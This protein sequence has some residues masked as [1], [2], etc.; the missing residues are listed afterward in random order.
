MM[1]PTAAAFSVSTQFENVGDAWIHRELIR[2]VAMRA[3]TWV[4]V[5][6]CPSGFVANLG[7]DAL[8]G[9]VRVDGL[10]RLLSRVLRHRRE[11]GQTAWF[12]GPGGYHGERSGPD[13][14]RAWVATGVLA[15]LHA[16]GARICLVG[17]SYERLGRRHR[18]VLATRGRLLHAHLVRDEA[19]AAYARSLG[20]NVHGIA[21][22]LAFADP[23]W[24]SQSP[25]D[26]VTV[27]LVFRSD[28][29]ATQQA[30]VVDF[31]RRLA[32]AAHWVPR[33]RAIAQVGRDQATAVAVADAVREAG[34]QADVVFVDHALTAARAAYVGCSHVLGNRLHGLLLGASTGAIPVPVVD[35]E[36]QAKIGGAFAVLPDGPQVIASASPDAV[37]RAA[38]VLADDH[39]RPLD[40]SPA[41]AVLEAAFDRILGPPSRGADD[42]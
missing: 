6:R 16:A 13:L 15:A 32:R 38:A 8:P 37:E 17:V 39:K 22:D 35:P 21:A 1:R 4:D 33:W 20:I 3:P 42:A 36:R 27:A 11:G 18:D 9:V 5:T 2:L 30:E 12:L 19:S 40:P 26:A 29:H 23:A 31:V 14:A 41:R 10:G 34:A 24:S 7:L 25:A 28:Q